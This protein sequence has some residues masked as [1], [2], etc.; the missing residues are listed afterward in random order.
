MVFDAAESRLF[1]L[2][3]RRQP[4]NRKALANGSGRLYFCMLPTESLPTSPCEWHSNCKKN[5][6]PPNRQGQASAEIGHMGHNCCHMPNGVD[7]R[8][9]L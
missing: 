6:F 8:I 9:I 7:V 2:V 1:G 4:S 5:L 3:N